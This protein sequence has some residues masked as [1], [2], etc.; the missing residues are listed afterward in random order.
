MCSSDLGPNLTPIGSVATMLWFVLLRQ[1]GYAVSSGAY[2]RMGLLV[3]PLTIAAAGLTALV[4][5]SAR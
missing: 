5:E 2:I 4:L 3:T 1:R